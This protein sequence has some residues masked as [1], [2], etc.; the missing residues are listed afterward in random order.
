MPK[1]LHP[2]PYNQRLASC[3]VCWADSEQVEIHH[4]RGSTYCEQHYWEVKEEGWHSV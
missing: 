2:S 3:Q 4:Y 1:P